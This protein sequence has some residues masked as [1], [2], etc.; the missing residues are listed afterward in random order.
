MASEFIKERNE[1]FKD[2]NE[3]KIKAYC[4]KY[5]IEIPEDEKIFWA[6]VHKTICNLYLLDSSDISIEQYNKSYDWLKENKFSPSI[7]FSNEDID[8]IEGSKP[9]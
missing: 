4:E 7:N 8:M 5:G 2:A 6:G 3:K 1:A 9:E